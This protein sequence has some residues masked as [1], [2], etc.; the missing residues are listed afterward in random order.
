[1]TAIERC[2]LLD[3]DTGLC[4]GITWNPFNQPSKMEVAGWNRGMCGARQNIAEQ[5]DC[6]KHP[7][8][9]EWIEVTTDDGTDRSRRLIVSK[10]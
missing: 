5:A 3:V 9:E 8:H 10:R 7:Q 6:T 2:P 4:A 1:M